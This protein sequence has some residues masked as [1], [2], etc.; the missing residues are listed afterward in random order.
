MLKTS[1]RKRLRRS[2]PKKPFRTVGIFRLNTQRS[3]LNIPRRVWV[4]AA[5]LVCA[6]LMGL[7]LE[8]SWSQSLE[9]R[10]GRFVDGKF[11][12]GFLAEKEGDRLLLPSKG[13]LNREEGTIE[14]WVRHVTS[15]RRRPEFAPLF[16]AQIEPYTTD[17]PKI[18]GLIVQFVE[19]SNQ[20]IFV[21][22][23]I[24]NSKNVL[25]T[26]ELDWRADKNHHVAV[27]WGGRGMRIYI[28]GR[29]VARNHYR[30]SLPNLPDKLCIGCY[31][32]DVINQ[33]A[34]A[35]IDDVRISKVQRSAVEIT[36]T[37]RSN[38]PVQADSHTLFVANFEDQSISSP[39][40]KSETGEKKAI[41]EKPVT[42]EHTT[43]SLQ[44]VVEQEARKWKKHD[45]RP[46]Y[47]NNPF[48]D[49]TKSFIGDPAVLYKDGKFYL[50]YP[51]AI[52]AYVAEANPLVV[53]GVTLLLELATSDDGVKWKKFDRGTPNNLKDDFILLPDSKR[54]WDSYGLETPTVLF[55]ESDKKFKMWYAGGN[56][57]RGFHIGYAE[58]SDAIQWKKYDNP[59][60]KRSSYDKSDPV[61]SPR[62]DNW[63]SFSVN[64]PV[65]IK[66][67][68]K[69][70]MWYCGIS[71]GFFKSTVAIGYAESD[72]G[73][74]WKRLDKPVLEPDEAWEG[75]M[76]NGPT[77]IKVKDY[78]EMWYYGS[79]EGIRYA[80]SRDGINWTKAKESVLL[81]GKSG[82]WDELEASSPTVT[83]VN[84]KYYMYYTGSKC[85]IEEEKR[86]S[87]CTPHIQIGLAIKER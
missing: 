46:V 35:V 69:F 75:T 8:E 58:S 71:T 27:S 18:R 82:D 53:D 70:K 52:H 37:Y 63:D 32:W 28:D 65:V 31:A 42:A 68:N 78:Y 59:N 23:E 40:V 7:G 16:T 4:V 55:D 47:Q 30:G 45:R 56:L 41:A 26:P 2:R 17:V 5:A 15:Q 76:A 83:F 14:M 66:E 13:N 50:F 44:A 84:G 10:G 85:P 60:T 54:S 48:G 62:K 38:K 72:D 25:A 73:I 29:E 6:F 86:K 24:G 61:M 19:R 21:L 39:I 36:E 49:G 11:G 80:V 87:E 34:Q 43:V 22:G 51:S 3:T 67:G 9:V 64:D 79:K 1:L 20:I 77:V 33:P 12:R 81:P 57:E 74:N